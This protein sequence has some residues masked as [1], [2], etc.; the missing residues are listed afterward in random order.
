MLYT[1]LFGELTKS[2]QIRIDK[3]S[4]LKK[5][6]FDQALFENYLDWDAPQIGLTF[7]ELI[8]VLRF[9]YRCCHS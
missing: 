6:L 9:E 1:S 3:A 4:E 5:Q 2:V 8:R 7:E